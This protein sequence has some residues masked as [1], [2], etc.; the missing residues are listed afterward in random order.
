MYRGDSRDLTLPTVKMILGLGLD[1]EGVL[2]VENL[3]VYGTFVA[4]CQQRRNVLPSIQTARRRFS[5][6]T[7]GLGTYSTVNG[8]RFDP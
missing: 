5:C 3:G 6:D 4:Q 1:S 2:W 8:T 7:S